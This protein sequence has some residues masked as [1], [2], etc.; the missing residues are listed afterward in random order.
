M[1]ITNLGA[2]I[3]SYY[4]M[5]KLWNSNVRKDGLARVVFKDRGHVDALIRIAFQSAIK[6]ADG[7]PLSEADEQAFLQRAV[8]PKRWWST[9]RLRRKLAGPSDPPAQPAASPAQ[10][11]FQV[12]SQKAANAAVQQAIRISAKQL[13]KDLNQQL[14]IHRI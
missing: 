13:A 4:H 10:A 11:A 7:E 2:A 6:E 8:D 14:T 3:D 9:L 12:V 5:Q 1:N